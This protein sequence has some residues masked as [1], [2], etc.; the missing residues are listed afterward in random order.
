MEI[1][2]DYLRTDEE[3]QRALEKL[4]NAPLIAL[5]TETTGLDPYT[6]KLLLLQISDQINN[7]VISFIHDNSFSRKDVE[8]PQWRMLQAILQGPAVK[9]AHNMVFDFKIIRA[10]FGYEMKNLYDTMIA[11]RILTVGKKGYADKLPRLKEVVPKYTD[12]TQ[13]DMRK[14]VRVSFY[15]GY[16]IEEFSENQLLY[17]ARD[18]AVLIPIYWKQYFALQEEGL[19]PV[20]QLE[21]RVLPVTASMEFVGVNLDIQA[22]ERAMDEIN[23]ERLKYRREAESYLKPVYKQGALFEDFC[24]ISIDSNSQVRKALQDLGLPVEDSVGKAVL[25]QLELEHPIAKALLKYRGLEKLVT[26]YGEGL[27]AKINPVTGRLHG[28]FWQL[29]TDTGRYSSSDP[30]LQNI[31]GAERCPLR[32]CFVPPEGY[33][34]LGADYSQQELRV[35]AAVANEQNMLEAYRNDEDIHFRT[36]VLV[37]KRNPREFK[38]LLDSRKRKID[39]QKDDLI[40]PAEHKANQ[41]RKIAKNCNFLISYGGGPSKLA[42]TANIPENEAKTIMR[43]HARAFP[44]LNQYIKDY[45][46]MGLN[47][48]SS[49]TLLGRKRYY[50]LPEHSDPNYFKIEAAIKRQAVNH[51]IQGTSGDITKS[52]LV[53]IQESFDTRFGRDKAYLWSVIHDETQAMV[54]EDLVEEAKEIIVSSMKEAFEEFIPEEV[55][56]VKVDAAWGRHWSH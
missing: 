35:I 18:S 48:L 5:D 32:D 4:L 34:A 14:E 40:T 50:W 30:N 39:E 33:V 42:V 8:S 52:A 19:M 49:S 20:A 6:C 27:L 44:A 16:K 21:F 36:A 9:I 23:K 10:H 41:Q 7:Y 15:A 28:R 56:P 43:D 54:R 26:G 24:P 53:K 46:D 25:E 55:C 29:G 3:I 45:G 47:N 17:A 31:P 2:Y 11:E 38:E 51:I 13:V 12:L 1:R 37:F 22:W